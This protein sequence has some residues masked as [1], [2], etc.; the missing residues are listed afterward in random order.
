MNNAIFSNALFA[1]L[2]EIFTHSEESLKDALE[3]FDQDGQLH[4]LTGPAFEDHKFGIW[5]IHG[6]IYSDLDSYVKDAKLSEAEA[7]M[8]S[9]RYSGALPTTESKKYALGY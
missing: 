5:A 8:L 9:L 1:E 4:C 2:V 6:E 7:I 3:Y